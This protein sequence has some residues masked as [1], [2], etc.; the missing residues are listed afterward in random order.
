MTWL[1]CWLAA[2]MSFEIMDSMWKPSKYPVVYPFSTLFTVSTVWSVLA[3]H[4][5]LDS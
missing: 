1:L 5:A 3:Q 2:G 4:R